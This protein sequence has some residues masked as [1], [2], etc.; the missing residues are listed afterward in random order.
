[1]Q[2]S[3]QVKTDIQNAVNAGKTVTVPKTNIA[4]D[5][6]T[7]VGYILFDPNTGAGA[8]MISGGFA[9]GGSDVSNIEII[10][11]WLLIAIAALAIVGLIEAMEGLITAISITLV[12]S[13]IAALFV[14]P[15]LLIAI[16]FILI[17]AYL[18]FKYV[19]LPNITFNKLYRYR[20]IYTT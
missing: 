12:E 19:I 15:I 9:G 6:W 8:Y 16:I 17:A 5:T 4:I 13:L 3:P 2:V 10:A 14:T 1:M 20:K 11:K 7:G 18:I